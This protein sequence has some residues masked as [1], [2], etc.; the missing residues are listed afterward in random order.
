MNECLKIS[1]LTS[2]QYS[3]I[4]ENPQF[5]SLLTQVLS[6]LAFIKEITRI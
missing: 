5:L 4:V 1:T 2:F 6:E 3:K